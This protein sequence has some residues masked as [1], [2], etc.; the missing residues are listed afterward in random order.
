MPTCIAAYMEPSQSTGPPQSSASSPSR[1]AFSAIRS[2]ALGWIVLFAI[3]YLVQNRLL[4]WLAPWIDPSWSAT[5]Y[6]A[7]ECGALAAA[8]WVAGR[9]NRPESMLAVFLLAVTLSLWNFRQA[10]AIDIPW[11]VRLAIDTLGDSRYLDSLLTTLANQ[12]LLFGC[13]FAGGLLSRPRPAPA[14]L[15]VSA[16]S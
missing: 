15:N 9:A 12:A 10:S 5:V 4:I 13:L 2:I 16:S 7:V 3:K 11:L 6:L 14:S 8:G 1:R